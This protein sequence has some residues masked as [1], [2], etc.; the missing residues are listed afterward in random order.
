[1]KYC[2]LRFTKDLDIFIAVDKEMK[3]IVEKVNV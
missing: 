1:M 2:E 3:E